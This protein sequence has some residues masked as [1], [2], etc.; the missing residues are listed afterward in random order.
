MTDRHEHADD[1]S[2][3]RQAHDC[4]REA[5]KHLRQVKHE[6]VPGN[7]G[8]AY[9]LLVDVRRCCWMRTW[10]SQATARGHGWG[11]DDVEGS[12]CGVG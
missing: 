2:R 6:R 10:G 3:I 8:E 1:D 12:R 7:V 11:D 9:Q 5:L 4:V